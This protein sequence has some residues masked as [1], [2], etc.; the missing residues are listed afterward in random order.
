MVL[1]KQL[2]L[3][4]KETSWGLKP[5]RPP[6]PQHSRDT[7][8]LCFFQQVSGKCQTWPWTR[9]LWGEIGGFVFSCCHTK[10]EW[11]WLCGACA[12]STVICSISFFW[13]FNHYWTLKKKLFSHPHQS[14]E[15]SL[16]S[17]WFTYSF[18]LLAP[19]LVEASQLSWHLPES[20]SS[21][22]LCFS[23][24]QISKPLHLQTATE[25]ITLWRHKHKSKYSVSK[26]FFI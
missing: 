22:S 18:Q 10:A 20:L 24:D 2:Q 1:E 14:D 15:P 17:D 6:D 23:M 16:W 21:L 11:G 26:T 19:A 4:N 7:F 9:C 13:S 5:L 12:P 3:K 8:V 25:I